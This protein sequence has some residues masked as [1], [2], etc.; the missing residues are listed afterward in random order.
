M[1][2]DSHYPAGT[3]RAVLDTDL[4][5]AQTSAAL[6]RRLQPSDAHFHVLS[7]DGLRLLVAICDRLIPQSDRESPIDLAQRLHRNIAIGDGDGWRYATLPGDRAALILGVA[8]VDASARTMTGM[9]FISLDDVGR[10][11]VLAAVQRGEAPHMEWEPTFQKRWFEELLV[12]LAELYFAHPIAQEEIGYLG[13]ADAQGWAEVGLGA[14]AA[15][16]PVE[17][18]SND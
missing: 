16:E 18:L 10:D 5:T 12:A 1:T 15:F 8:A 13:M 14:R 3:V 11:T 2:D 17:L 6:R 7:A 9:S 4:V